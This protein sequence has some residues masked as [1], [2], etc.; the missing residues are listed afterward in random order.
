MNKDRIKRLADFFYSSNSS[1]DIPLRL[2]ITIGQFTGFDLS[3]T[4]FIRL[5]TILNNSEDLKTDLNLFLETFI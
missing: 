5:M 2:T 1:I 3:K 4:E